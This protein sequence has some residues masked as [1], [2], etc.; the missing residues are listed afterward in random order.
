MSVEPAENLETDRCPLG[1]PILIRSLHF[2]R[3]LHLEAA[4]LV[5]EVEVTFLSEVVEVDA[6]SESLLDVNDLPRQDGPL[7]H[8]ERVGT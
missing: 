1:Q 3:R 8:R 7:I 6:M 4:F 2:L 5:A